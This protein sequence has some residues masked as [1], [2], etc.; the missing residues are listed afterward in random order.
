MNFKNFSLVLIT[1][2]LISCSNKTTSPE[3]IQQVTGRYLFNPDETIE[4]Y[5]EDT[6][7]MMKW[8]GA[9]KI[10]PMNL[11]DNNFYVKEMNEK[12]QFLKN[13]KDQK[14][15]ICLV[16]KDKNEEIK[17]D[18]KKLND[19]EDVPS[20]YLKNKE[21]SKALEGFK[22]IKEK[23][24]AKNY[25]DEYK[26]NRIGYQK[27]RDKE[28]IE[29][30]EIFKVNIALFPESD[31]VYDSLAEAYFRNK[32]TINAIENYKKAIAIDSGNRAAKRFLKKY[33]KK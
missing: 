17:F 11:G 9:D 1:F 33:D 6:N 22:V 3:F 8:R 14:Q 30:I 5:F 10:T 25:I 13:P 27:L 21:Y 29:A 7:L 16:P 23:D 28:Y 31:N 4:V 15:Y 26:I 2:L 24:T 32:D 18:F 20:N 12:I 19:N